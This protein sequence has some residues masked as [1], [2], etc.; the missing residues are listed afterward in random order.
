MRKVL[1]TTEGQNVE[2]RKKPTTGRLSE[3]AREKQCGVRSA[4]KPLDARM[5]G[6]GVGAIGHGRM[7]AWEHEGVG[8]RASDPRS[9]I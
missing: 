9:K 2:R 5:R 1:D 4:K 8:E 7:G 6:H 3:R